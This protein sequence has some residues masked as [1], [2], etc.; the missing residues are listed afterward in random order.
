MSKVH[1]SLRDDIKRAGM[2]YLKVSDGTVYGPVQL[3][4]LCDWAAE[5]RIVPGSTISDNKRKWTPAEH[6]Q[7]LKMDWMAEL[8]NGHTYGPLNVLA[9]P[10]LCENGTL[11]SD[12]K[13]VNTVSGK[14]L[15]VHQLLKSSGSPAMDQ[16]EG[17]RETEKQWKALYREEKKTRLLHEAKLQHTIDELHLE[18]EVSHDLLDKAQH[19]VERELHEYELLEK[20]AASKQE[21]LKEGVE[22]LHKD[23]VELKKKFKNTEQELVKQKR[24][25]VTLVDKAASIEKKLSGQIK[26]LNE[27]L[28]AA[29]DELDNANARSAEEHKNI[30]ALRK[31]IQQKEDAFSHSLDH[32]RRESE[33]HASL[34]T[35]AQ[36]R[37]KQEETL[38]IDMQTDEAEKEAQLSHRIQELET[39]I[40]RANNALK[41]RQTRVEKLEQ[42]RQK[43]I[44]QLQSDCRKSDE[45][46]EELKAQ[47]ASQKKHSHVHEQETEARSLELKQVK[48]ELQTIL[49]REKTL[50]KKLATFEAKHIEKT[51]P[52]R[53]RAA[54]VS[55]YFKKISTRLKEIKA[56]S[57]PF[58]PLIRL[59]GLLA[60]VAVCSAGAFFMGKGLQTL[61][62]PEPVAVSGAASLP[63]PDHRATT[64]AIEQKDIGKEKAAGLKDRFIDLEETDLDLPP[65]LLTAQQEQDALPVRRILWPRMDIDNAIVDYGD[66]A[67]TIIFEYGLFV[68]MTN[69]SS[70]A[71]MT[72]EQVASQLREHMLRFILIIEGHTDA[73]PMST[74]SSYVDNYAL[75]MARATMVLNLLKTRFNMPVDSM[76]A[77]SAGKDDP[78]Y[79]HSDDASRKKNRTVVLKLVPRDDT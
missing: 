25:N 14:I 36:E 23:T 59:A 42:E 54:R 40:D 19:E 7:A 9:V 68:S 79:P 52:V 38:L 71:M 2:W 44:Q 48:A 31:Q 35:Q 49:K 75:G 47:L 58:P 77:T 21:R 29:Q 33:A 30:E 32:V 45:A 10:H 37:L 78:P 76:F 5:S 51:E 56:L 46:V 67:C 17:V 55:D 11:S 72:L 24:G 1:D 39:E 60:L 73:V 12:T 6:H 50:S 8:S 62:S 20:K 61:P 34:L 57:K 28:E 13:L 74:A 43:H 18:A 15:Y 3:S 22:T 63:P 4:V 27:Q 64:S 66:K 16:V 70:D 26:Q 65:L 69:L 53:M 41:Q